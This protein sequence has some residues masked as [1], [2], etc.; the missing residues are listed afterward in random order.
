MVKI[1]IIYDNTVYREGLE[2]DWGF[3]CLV[4]AHNKKILF[5]TGTSG[6]MLLDNM[7]KLNIDPGIVE[8]VFISHDHWDHTGGLHDFLKINPVKV[9]VPATYYSGQEAKE[10]IS[11]KEP[12]EI[13]DNIFTTGEL[14]NIEQSLLIATEKGLVV[15]VGCSHPGVKNILQAAS[16]YGKPWALVG[17]LHGFSELH[18]LEELEFV[19]AT[20]CTQYMAEI[21]KM[22]PQKYIEGGAGREIVF[23]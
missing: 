8:E 18:L 13:H 3:S 6:R 10:T 20:H 1:T 21:K 9:Y 5:D 17:G 2:S 16:E 19:C 7:K 11:I 15:V 12:L 23:K 22:Y 14:G 4:E